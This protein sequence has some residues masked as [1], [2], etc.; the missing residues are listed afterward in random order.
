MSIALEIRADWSE[1]EVLWWC[2]PT[3]LC[4]V[5]KSKQFCFQSSF[6]SA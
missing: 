2:G 4:W 6:K 1:W 3:V 5:C